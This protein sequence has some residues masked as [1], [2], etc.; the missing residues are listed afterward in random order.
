[1]RMSEMEYKATQQAL[2]VLAV[3]VEKLD[4]PAFLETARRADE[5]GPFVDPTLWMKG[6]EPLK[7][8]IALAESLNAFRA[9]G[10]K[11]ADKA[12]QNGVADMTGVLAE[13]MTPMAV[14]TPLISLLC[15]V[16]AERAVRE[17]QSDDA[18]A[19]S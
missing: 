1:M 5:I 2:G 18:A 8:V 17:L 19:P 10:R 15:V 14:V 4:L 13:Q 6:T 9:T 11:L 16:D 7:G 12:R 3:V